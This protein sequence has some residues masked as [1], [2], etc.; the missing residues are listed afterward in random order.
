MIEA[1]RAARADGRRRVLRQVAAGAGHRRSRIVGAVRI[2]SL[3]TAVAVSACGPAAG[4]VAPEVAPRLAL[5][6]CA[7][8]A[9][10]PRT[11]IDPGSPGVPVGGA[12]GASVTARRLDGGGG[13]SVIAGSPVVQGPLDRAVIERMV[14]GYLPELRGCYERELAA[15]PAMTGAV[16][17]TFTAGPD[18]RVTT[19][20]VLG[21]GVTAAVSA[22]VV[23]VVQTLSFP[24]GQM[25]S[26]RY[27]FQFVTGGDP[28]RSAVETLCSRTSCSALLATR[29]PWT[30]YATLDEP[31]P[32]TAREVARAAEGAIRRGLPAIA[33]C[34]SGPAP[35]GSL[36]A[37]LAVRG[38]AIEVAR[39]GGLGDATEACVA[40]Q[41]IGLGVA[42]RA[43]NAV[44]I[45]CD[46]ARGEARP[47]RVAPAAGYAVLEAGRREVRHGDDVVTP[48]MI[49][50]RPLPA[51]QTFLVVA[52]PD[53]PGAML[54]LALEWAEQGDATLIALRDGI[55]APRLVGAARTAHQLGGREPAAARAALQLGRGTVTA[56]VDRGAQAASLAD[57]AAIDALVRRVA[58]RCRALGCTG[59]LGVAIDSDATA[60]QLLE[61]TGAVRRAGFERVLLGSYTGCPAAGPARR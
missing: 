25:I 58:D 59:S 36:R 2:A 22:C 18:G 37:M 44:E 39:A 30:P 48:G 60:R 12:P 23:R 34:F 19:T 55:G 13:P 5:V 32:R 54:E 10:L 6:G 8:A 31:P 47:W 11:A 49:A 40:R 45:A 7:P 50:P 16:T 41:L 14:R 15:D 52:S 28:P 3:V 42:A 57:P 35:V 33:G 20:S 27:P 21:S 61:V 29:A 38:G 17:V 4:P 46:F 51:G 26:V 24:A 56:C 43:D 9:P 1:R 53:T